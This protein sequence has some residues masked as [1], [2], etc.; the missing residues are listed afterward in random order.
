MSGTRRPLA[1]RPLT[2][3]HPS[4]LPLEHPER[5]R[6]LAA[7]AAALAAGDAGYRDP[8][9]GLFVLTAGFLARRGTCCD[10]GCRHCPYVT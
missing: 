9:T 1:K 2:E 3:P 6:I 10:Q 4:R 8:V 5:E 7:H